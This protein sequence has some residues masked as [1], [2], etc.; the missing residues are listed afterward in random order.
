MYG[1]VTGFGLD[2]PH[3]DAPAYDPI[4]QAQVGFAAVQGQG[5]ESPEFVRTLIC[6]KVPAY[7]ISQAVTT[8]LFVRERTGEGQ[9]IDLSMMDAGLY[10]VFPDGF[11]H[12]TLLDDDATDEQP[13]SEL[14]YEMAETADGGIIASAATPAQQVGLLTAI[15]RLDLFAEPRFDSM[16][17]IIANLDAFREEMRSSMA[18]FTTDDLL[19]RLHANDVPAAR[20]LDY[21]EVFGHAQFAANASVDVADHPAMGSM[22]RVLPPVRFGGEQLTA[23]AHAPGHGEHTVEILSELGHGDDHIARLLDA[24]VAREPG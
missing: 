7:T 4:I 21:D 9:H 23:A 17:K 2:G 5:K 14:L 15:E 16:E 10:F 20:P 22:R 11:M 3:R 13:L 8:A 6:D 19:E 24:D 1:A 18:R 12:R